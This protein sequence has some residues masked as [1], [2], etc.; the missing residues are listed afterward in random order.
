MIVPV[1]FTTVDV[2]PSNQG[3]I[4][5]AFHQFHR[6]N[7]EVYEELVSLA[8]ELKKRGYQKFGIATIYEVARWRSMLR[9]GPEGQF[10]LNNNYRAYYARLMMRNVAEL[11]GIFDTRTLAVPH[12]VAP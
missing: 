12:H 5:E 9:A 2:N 6:E 3:K 11:D 4:E 8:R 7:P 1:V 10:K